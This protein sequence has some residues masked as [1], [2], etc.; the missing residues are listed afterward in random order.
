MPENRTWWTVTLTDGTET[1]PHASH[2]GFNP[3]GPQGPEVVFYGGR[4]GERVDMRLPIGKVE[5]IEVTD[6]D[7]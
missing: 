2:I 6:R 7:G 1:H 4:G 3:I 5:R